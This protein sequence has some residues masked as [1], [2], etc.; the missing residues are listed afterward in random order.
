MRSRHGRSPRAVSASA[1]II[2][3]PKRWRES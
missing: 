3:K 1:E 2:G